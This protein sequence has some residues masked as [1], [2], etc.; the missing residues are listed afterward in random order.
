MK[1]LGGNAWA[2]L[3]RIDRPGDPADGYTYLHEVR[4]HQHTIVV[5]ALARRVRGRL[6]VL[7]RDETCPAWS[8][9]DTRTTVVT[10]GGEHDDHRHHATVEVAEETGYQLDCE[11]LVEL[12][13]VF[14]S[15]AS[16]AVYVLYG[17]D[18][19]GLQPGPAS[20]DGTALDV[21]PHRWVAA[22]EV[23][24]DDAVAECCVRRLCDVLE[25]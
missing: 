22:T 23:R 16:D 8:V 21:A 6:E 3:H 24:F 12:G 19:G 9:R 18:I 11:M 25:R 2:E 14:G 4:A 7:V 1:V 15:K 20:G 10:G 5:V 13:Q 17:A